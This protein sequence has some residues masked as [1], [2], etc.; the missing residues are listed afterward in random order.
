MDEQDQAQQAL[1]EMFRRDQAEAQAHP[2]RK[3]RGRLESLPPA[4]VVAVVV[5]VLI[6]APAAFLVI[7]PRFGPVDTMTAFC[8]AE[9]DGDYSTAYALL[10]KGAQQRVSLDAFTQASRNAQ[11]MTCGVEHGI[12]IILRETRASLDASYQL[13]GSNEAIDGTMGFVR[14]GDGWRVDS[15]TPDYFHL[16]S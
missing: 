6:L 3:R 9:T 15:T 4:W 14:E 7:Y 12:P 5:V 16:S 10:S 8:T 11:V 2:G 13:V 1:K